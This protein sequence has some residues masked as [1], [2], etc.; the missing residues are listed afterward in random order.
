[1]SKDLTKISPNNICNPKD[2]WDQQI[3]NQRM[4]WSQKRVKNKNN[5]NQHSLAGSLI[6]LKERINKKAEAKV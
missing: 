4:I 5:I 3:Q 2:G 6:L 1:M